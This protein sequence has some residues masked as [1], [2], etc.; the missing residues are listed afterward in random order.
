[1]THL[2]PPYHRRPP[3]HSVSS[4][5]QSASA[6]CLKARCTR[7]RAR[8]LASTPSVAR[9]S[10]RSRRGSPASATS[11]PRRPPTHHQP[12]FAHSHHARV[13]LGLQPPNESAATR[14]VGPKALA[15]C[16]GGTRTTTPACL[17]WRVHT[18]VFTVQPGRGYRRVAA[19]LG[20]VGCA[21]H[22]SPQVHEREVTSTGYAARA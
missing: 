3:R 16:T 20:L 2:A 9:V 10:V 4:C 18:Y 22:T 12:T 14:L 7:S 19:R 8:P 5:T 6:A 13:R 17:L 1:M 11:P 15:V 21:P